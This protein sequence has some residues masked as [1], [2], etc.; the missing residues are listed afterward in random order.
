MIITSKDNN[1]F[2]ELLY[3]KTSKGRKE[4][5]KFIVEGPHLVKEAKMKNILIEAYSIKE[6]EGYNILSEALMKK[7]SSTSS[8]VEE[9]GVCKIIENDN[10]SDKIIILDNVQDPG[11][12]GAIMRSACAFGFKT[13]I[14]G[15]GCCDIYND[16]VIRSSQGAIFKLSF[17]HEN[18]INF[19]PTLKD[20][21]VYGTDVRN[22]IKLDDI[23][24]NNKL[25]I[26]LGNEGNGISEEVF[27]L[28]NKNIY[29]PMDD[30]E[31]LNVSVAASIIMYKLR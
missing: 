28:L 4:L 23:K 5:N 9:I 17:R 12:I 19:I 2:K 13:I 20:Y 31:S 26:I 11:N 21:D 30:T 8:V 10:L 15:E 29:I 6:K 3:L 1:K 22:G 7:I 27:K 14:L 18:L 24:N 25:A 16:K